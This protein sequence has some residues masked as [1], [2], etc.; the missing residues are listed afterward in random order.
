MPLHWVAWSLD[1]LSLTISMLMT[2]SC[3]FP[4]HQGTLLWHW[5]AYSHAWPWINWIWTQIK[6][7]SSVSGMNDCG[8]NTSICFLLSFMWSK[9]TQQSCSESC[10]LGKIS[11]S[12]HI[13]QQCTVHAFTISGICSIFAITLSWIL[14]NY[15]QLFLC[16]VI[17]IIIIHGVPLSLV[18]LGI[19]AL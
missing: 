11:P 19:L 2:A 16:P 6:L 10:N 4:L 14:Q 12:A 8:T 17:S 7:I 13:Y 15:W 9:L 18:S 5:M 1:T 3:M